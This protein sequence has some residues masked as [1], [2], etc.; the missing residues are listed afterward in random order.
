MTAVGT[1]EREVAATRITRCRY[2][3]GD[4]NRCTAEAADPDGEVVLCTRHLALTLTLLR[5]HGVP[6]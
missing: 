6:V 1:L 2:L 4:D 5:S 3:V